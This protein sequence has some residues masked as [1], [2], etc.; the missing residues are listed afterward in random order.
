MNNYKFK[1]Y[2]NIKIASDGKNK[3]LIHTDSMTTPLE[4]LFQ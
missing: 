3:A 2:R 1:R 4:G